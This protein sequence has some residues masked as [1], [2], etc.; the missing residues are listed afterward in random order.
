MTIDKWEQIVEQLQAQY[1]DMERY[2]EPLMEQEQER[3]RA[4]V[5]S[6]ESAMGPLRVVLESR[7]VVVDKHLHYSHRPG[8]T[9]R[10]EYTYSETEETHRLRVYKEIDGDWQE[11]SAEKIFGQ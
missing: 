3:G 8:D 5:L 1:P 4:D 10:S 2:R 9:A 11:I 7:P 6:F